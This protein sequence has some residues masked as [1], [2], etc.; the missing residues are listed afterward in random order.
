MGLGP[1]DIVEVSANEVTRVG[2]WKV[3][4]ETGSVERRQGSGRPLVITEDIKRIVD[5]A[6]QKDNEITAVQLEKFCK[7]RVILLT[8]SHCRGQ[9]GWTF[10]GSAYCQL[11]RA[12][13]KDWNGHRKIFWV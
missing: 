4:D 2:V 6:L 12:A 9:P 7:R 8:I 3:Y 11:I 10:R 5:E 1:A 13:N